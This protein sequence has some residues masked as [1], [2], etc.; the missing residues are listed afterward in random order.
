LIYAAARDI[1]ERKEQEKEVEYLSY[2]DQLT[3]LYNRRYMEDSLRRMDTERNYPLCI[4]IMDVNGLKMANDAFGHK[5]GDN[6]L[7]TSADILKSVTRADDILCRAGGDEF[8]LI[9]P[10]TGHDEAVAIKK[11][12]T[13][14]AK[15]TLLDSIVV[16]M[17][18][19]YEIKTN[20]N[21]DIT[22][23]K[24]K[25]MQIC[26]GINLKMAEKC[27]RKL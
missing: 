19:G 7:I 14:K 1:T 15:K 5:M 9:L 23:F 10:N 20:I 2:H 25:L 3:G 6:L 22:I 17:A 21:Q 11:R 8:M 13:E 24:G 4:M 27:V 16:S 18:V 12:I 26:T